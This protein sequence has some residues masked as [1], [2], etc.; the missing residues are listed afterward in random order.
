MK[1]LLASEILLLFISFPLNI[2]K[3]SDLLHPIG[4]GREAPTETQ[5]V[6]STIPDNNSNVYASEYL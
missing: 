2:E 6:E 5:D 1:A 4:C 3:S